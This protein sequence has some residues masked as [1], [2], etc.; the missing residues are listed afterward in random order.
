MLEGQDA[1]EAKAKQLIN[2]A[3]S[4]LEEAGFH[5]DIAT[6]AHQHTRILIAMAHPEL[7]APAIDAQSH[8]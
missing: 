5:I 1:R 4:M 8:V 6:P 3:V 7:D 2:A